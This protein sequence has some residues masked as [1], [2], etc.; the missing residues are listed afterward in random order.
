MKVLV[1]SLNPVKINAVKEAFSKYFDGVTAVGWDISSGVPDQPIG[2]EIFEGAKNRAQ[3]LKK[4]N[5]SHDLQ[6]DYFVGI[7]G[8]VMK[9]FHKYRSFGCMCIIDKQDRISFGTSP[10]YE[11][12]E[13]IIKE[14]LKGVELGKVTDRL[15]GEKNTK[16]KG[17]TVGF[18]T[19][20]VMD[21]KEFYVHGLTVALIP[22][23]NADKYFSEKDQASL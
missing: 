12:P 14:L 17:G 16:H 10:Q 4:L 2:D 13:F 18:L 19:K 11:L 23:I 20:G 1:G 3:E 9:G 15:T 5:N 7:E 6:A 8:G 21:R 22:F